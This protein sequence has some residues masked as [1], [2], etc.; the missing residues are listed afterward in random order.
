[1][2]ILN[3]IILDQGD[4]IQTMAPQGEPRRAVDFYGRYMAIWAE[5]PDA[6]WKIARLMLSP[7]RQPPPR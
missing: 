2:T 3:G 5:Q 1:V 4:F 7:K 6:S